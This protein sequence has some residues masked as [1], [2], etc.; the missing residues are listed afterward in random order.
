[1]CYQRLQRRRLSICDNLGIDAIGA[2]DGS[3]ATSAAPEYYNLQ[4]I[5][6]RG[7]V[8]PGIYILRTAG[9]TT[10]ILVK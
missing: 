2:V 9:R 7:D 8:T 3:D 1:M 6:V 10:K 4:G 5:R